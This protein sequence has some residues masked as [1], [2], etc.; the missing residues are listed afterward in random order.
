M[1]WTSMF[2]TDGA[3]KEIWLLLQNEACRIHRNPQTKSS[4]SN[5]LQPRAPSPFVMK[6]ST[7]TTS[8][9]W[10]DQLDYVEQG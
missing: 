9:W 1:R 8:R 5:T 10:N 7:P 2:T 3:P 6:E 4:Q